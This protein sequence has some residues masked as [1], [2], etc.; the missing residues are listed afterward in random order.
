MSTKDG[1]RLFLEAEP[2]SIR[3]ARTA[4]ATL[5]EEIGIGEPALGDVKTVVSEACSNVVRHAYPD[6][7]GSFELEAFAAGEE[8]SIVVRDFGS[9]VKPRL[10]P[11]PGGL[12]LGIGLISSLSSHYEISGHGEGGTE[13]RISVPISA[14]A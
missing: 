8:I 1:L 2:Q 10:E 7:S 11:D 9:G 3:L 13:V 5:A 4:V 12:R 6:G 14:S